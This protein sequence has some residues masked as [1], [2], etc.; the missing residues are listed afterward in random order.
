VIGY[1]VSQN[2]L[3]TTVYDLRPPDYT[4]STT[5]T[6]NRLLIIVILKTN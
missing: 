5:T 1:I 3:E 6:T 2:G 4:T